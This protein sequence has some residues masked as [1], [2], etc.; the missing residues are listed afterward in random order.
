MTF[1]TKLPHQQLLFSCIVAVPAS[2][3]AKSFLLCSLL[4]LDVILVVLKELNRERSK[5]ERKFR[6]SFSGR[7][8]NTVR[9]NKTI[10]QEKK[11]LLMRSCIGSLRAFLLNSSFPFF[12]VFFRLIVDYNEITEFSILSLYIWGLLTIASLLLSLQMELVKYKIY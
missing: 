1:Y 9:M 2:F 5:N 3:K 8:C 10:M 7:H 6:I 11:Q 12:V 4:L